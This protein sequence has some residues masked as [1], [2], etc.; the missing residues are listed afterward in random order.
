MTVKTLTYFQ[1]NRRLMDKNPWDALWFRGLEQRTQKLQALMLGQPTTCQVTL[2]KPPGF[3]CFPSAN[4]RMRVTQINSP[5]PTPFLRVLSFFPIWS[6]VN[7]PLLSTA[8]EYR[9]HRPVFWFSFAWLP[10]FWIAVSKTENPNVLLRKLKKRR[11]RRSRR[12][13]RHTQAQERLKKSSGFPT[14]SS[15]LLVFKKK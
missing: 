10:L 2:Y 5:V 1:D 14:N 6:W 15:Y 3:P 9:N 7:L 8:K 13:C 11:E 12:T 4:W